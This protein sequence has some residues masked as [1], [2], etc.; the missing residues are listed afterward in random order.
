MLFR[1]IDTTLH[2]FQGDFDGQHYPESFTDE[3]RA[4][5][6]PEIDATKA[7]FALDFSAPECKCAAGM[8]Y[9]NI[10][11]DGTVTRCIGHPTKVGGNF[12]REPLR[13]ADAPQWCFKKMCV[14][15]QLWPYQIRHGQEFDAS[16]LPCAESAV[17]V[18]ASPKGVVLT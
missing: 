10:A 18:H 14:C 15:N 6:T 2:P 4:I 11:L 1:S 9:A 8:L 13:F 3:Q 7:K 16:C 17:T 12:F 5:I